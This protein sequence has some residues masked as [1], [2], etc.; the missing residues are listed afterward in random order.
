MEGIAEKALEFDA[1]KTV[2]VD[3]WKGGLGKIQFFRISEKGLDAVPPLIYI[4]DIKLRR[5][6]RENTPKGRRIK[7]VAMASS[8]KASSEVKRLENALS[9]FFGIPILPFDEVVNRKYDAAMQI[10]ADLSNCI[11]ITF[12]L[13]PKL[14]EVGPQ[15][16]VSHLVWELIR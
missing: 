10:S 15:L 5:D 12:K 14:V 6:F 7:S 8:R 1:E 2:I 4:R 13:I 16:R 3:R 11:I 9:E